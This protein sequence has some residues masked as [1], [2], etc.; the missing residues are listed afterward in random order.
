MDYQ[1][2]RFNVRD[3]VARIVLN[4]PER[5]NSINADV[6][7]ELMAASIQCDEDP[8]VR[9]IL[10][11]GEGPMFSGGGDLKA[12]VRKKGDLPAYLKLT[13]TYL[14]A[15][16]S[17]FARQAAPTMCA[18]H[19]FAAGGGFSLAIACDLVV[20]AESAKFTMAYTRAGLTPDGS[21]TYFLARYVGLR[22]AMDMALTNRVV[23]AR[24]ALDWGLI[25]RVSKDESLLDDA[26]DLARNL[27]AGATMALGATKDLLHRGTTESL[28]T[29]MELETRAIAEAVRRDDGQEGILAFVE[30]RRP[31]FTG[32]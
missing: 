11:R 3:G 29:Q 4:R 8:S 13:T 14:H 21:S 28:E 9:A 6:A 10:I 23:T 24:E 25:S 16:I 2:I 22:R 5:A 30:K 27:A 12:F 1:S 32:Q 19:G 20:A 7:K 31:H 17:R 15:A 18:V 26:E